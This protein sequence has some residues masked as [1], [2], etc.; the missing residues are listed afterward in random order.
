M[1]T[2]DYFATIGTPLRRGRVFDASDDERSTRVA[3]VDE[4]FAKHFWPGEDPIG[5]RFKHGG[6]TSSGRWLTVIGV[7]ANVKHRSLDEPGDLQEYEPFSQ[8]TT[9]SNYLVVRTVA[10]RDGLVTELRRVLMSLDPAVPLF[11]VRSM[12]EAV[13]FSLGTRR[14]TSVLLAGFSV[15]AL[16][17]AAIGIYG[18]MS[19]GVNGRVREF[20]IRLALGANGG[21]VRGLVLRQAMWLALA[22]VAAGL[23]GAAATTRFLR[24]LL[25]GVGPLD[26]VT[27]GGVALLLTVTALIASY[28]PARRA[29]RAD[30]MLALRSE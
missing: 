2:P 3:V 13:D 8:R 15:T 27:F 26:W 5:K 21:A 20:G 1:V 28:L 23:A 6:D 10:E 7:V 9:W 12:R 19:L 24:T 17:L 18:V 16:L 11:E 30:P 22:G 29:T 25:F 14:L 4:L